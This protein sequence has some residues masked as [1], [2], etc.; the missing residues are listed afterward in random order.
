[1]QIRFENYSVSAFPDLSSQNKDMEKLKHALSHMKFSYT[2][3]LSDR[4][5]QGGK[6]GG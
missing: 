2:D 4:Q 5:Q 3:S 1:M 6:E